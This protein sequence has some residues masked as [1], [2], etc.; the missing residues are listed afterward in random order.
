MLER[1][2]VTPE[3]TYKVG[4]NKK[5]AKSAVRARS[6]RLAAGQLALPVL[7]MKRTVS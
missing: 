6:A 7:P 3:N 4:G 1:Y 2:Y 5:W